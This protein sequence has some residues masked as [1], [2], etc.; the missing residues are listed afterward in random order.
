M[1]PCMSPVMDCLPV[2]LNS[3]TARSAPACVYTARM[4][5]PSLLFHIS[6]GV[7]ALSLAGCG[8]TGKLYLRP[9]PG[10][11]NKVRRL[12]P[13]VTVVLPSGST[14]P[15][16]AAATHPAPVPAAATRTPPRP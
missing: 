16:P 10:D 5:R 7:L 14:Y 12:P 13:A 9:P 6:A 4:C 2:P 15:L 1:A 3:S 11:V 8:Q